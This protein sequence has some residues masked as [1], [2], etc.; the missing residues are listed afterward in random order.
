MTSEVKTR[1]TVILD[2]DRKYVERVAEKLDFMVRNYK[3]MDRGYHV[4]FSKKEDIITLKPITKV[5]SD[6][7]VKEL[8]ITGV[9]GSEA[10]IRIEQ[11][12]T[13]AQFP[14]GIT[15]D[16]NDRSTRLHGIP[17][18]IFKLSTLVTEENS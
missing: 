13:Y 15:F 4:F 6:N 1:A 3:S 9:F 8:V 7:P 18:N 16:R 2:P 14:H 10:T 5:M 12:E 17:E 11:V